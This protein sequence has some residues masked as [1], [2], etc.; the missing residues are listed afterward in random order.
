ML[1]GSAIH[2]T[3]DNSRS[4]VGLVQVNKCHVNG[5]HNMCMGVVTRILEGM[6]T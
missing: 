6:F 1:N 5:R 3:S 2:C 4:R